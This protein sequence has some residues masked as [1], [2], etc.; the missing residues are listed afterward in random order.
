MQSGQSCCEALRNPPSSSSRGRLVWTM[1]GCIIRQ[2]PESSRLI[3]NRQ[4]EFHIQHVFEHNETKFVRSLVSGDDRYCNH[5][6]SQLVRTG[7][8]CTMAQPPPDELTPSQPEILVAS[9]DVAAPSNSHP[10]S[11]K[12]C[13]I[14]QKEKLNQSI[15]VTDYNS[16]RTD[17]FTLQCVP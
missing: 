14:Y 2:G 10:I 1:F 17:R 16:E 5:Y 3:G 4:F 15:P 9:L 12:N 6:Y 7:V 11:V 8:K 13:F